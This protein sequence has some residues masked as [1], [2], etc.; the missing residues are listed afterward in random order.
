VAGTDVQV[1]LQADGPILWAAPGLDLTAAVVERL[2][3]GPVQSNGG[4]Q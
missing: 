1:V 3:A 4:H 2:N